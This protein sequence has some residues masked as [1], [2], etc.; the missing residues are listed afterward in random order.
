MTDLTRRNLL[1]AVGL[2]SLA[3]PILAHDSASDREREAIRLRNFP[4]VV[5]RT[6]ENKKVRFYEDLIKGKIVMINFMYARC[7]GVCPGITSNL[8]RVQKL[9]GDRVGSDIFMYSISLKPEED[10]PKVLKQYARAHGVGRGWTFLTGALEDIETLRRKLGARDPDPLLDA[11]KSQHTG[12][13]RYGNEPQ[14]WWA[15]FAGLA[16]PKWIVET[17]SWIDTPISRSP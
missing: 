5:L 15:A 9:L 7:E 4:D 12:I 14:R 17:I 13:V 2:S 6:H 8:V 10:T 11:D 1:A 16:H 3:G